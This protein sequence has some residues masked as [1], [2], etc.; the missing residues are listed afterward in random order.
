MLHHRRTLAL[1]A[2]AALAVVP[3]ARAQTVQF[4]GYT[5]GCFYT[6]GPCSSGD[7]A[8]SFVGANPFTATSV[9]GA[10]TDVKLGTFSLGGS[11]YSIDN[12]FGDN[13]FLKVVFTLPTLTDPT[14]VYEASLFGAVLPGYGGG[15]LVHFT[16]PPQVFTFNGPTSSGSFTLALQDVALGTGLIGNAL[17]LPSKAYLDGYIS[18]QRSIG[19]T[20]TPEPATVG[21]LA[22][23]LVGLI[24]AARWRKRSEPAA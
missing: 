7:E 6:N 12:Y 9:N 11:G 14:Q 22:L 18:M 4:A 19:T 13:F 3:S 16:T 21:L 1:I 15:A 8:L 24:P 20:T 2:V 17:D 5:T 23:G 10:P